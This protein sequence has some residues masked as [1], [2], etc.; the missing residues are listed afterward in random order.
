MNRLINIGI[1]AAVLAAS[2]AVS[3]GAVVYLGLPVVRGGLRWIFGPA[4]VLVSMALTMMGKVP[5]L[6]EMKGVKVAVVD[7]LE[8]MVGAIQL[9][10]WLM[11]VPTALAALTGWFLS[12]AP[13]DFDTATGMRI[14]VWAVLATIVATVLFALIYLPWLQHDYTQFRIRV[15]REAKEREQR[16]AVLKALD[17]AASKSA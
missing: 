12:L 3:Y 4:T 16:E 2:M 6:A 8:C 9:R 10:L 5:E 7:R 1:L 11:V 17:E 15:A 14:A 13:P